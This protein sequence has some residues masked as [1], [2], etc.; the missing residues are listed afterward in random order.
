[1]PQLFVAEGRSALIVTEGQVDQR[2]ESLDG[3]LLP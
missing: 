2:L 3:W 1:M